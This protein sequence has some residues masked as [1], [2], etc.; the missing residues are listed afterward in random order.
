MSFPT[1]WDVEKYHV[2]HE[3]DEHWE[4]RRRF[5]ETHKDKFPED[6][7]VCLAQVFYNVE[8]MGCRYPEKT[9]RLVAQLSKGVAD[10]HREKMKTKLQRTF[11]QASDAASTKA[12]GGFRNSDATP[13][14]N[15]A[16]E[17][18]KSSDEPTQSKHDEKQGHNQDAHHSSSKNNISSQET[19]SNQG[20]SE[21]TQP[22]RKKPSKKKKKQA[23]K[24]KP[25]EDIFSKPNEDIFSRIVIMENKDSRTEPY[26]TL[27]RSASVSGMTLK[28]DCTK[29]GPKHLVKLFIND[30]LLAAAHGDSMAAAKKQCSEEG[31]AKLRKC[32]YT[33]II[34]DRLVGSVVDKKDVSGA[35]SKVDGAS[36]QHLEDSKASRM[37]KL[38]GWGGGGLGK[39]QQG[40]EEPVQVVEQVRRAGLG[41]HQEGEKVFR[42][43]IT[44]VIQEFKRSNANNELVFASDFSK[45][46]RALIH[47]IARKFN[48]KSVSYGKDSDRQL[49]LSRKKKP[50]EIVKEVLECGGSTDKY[51]IKP[52]EDN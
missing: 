19:S 44:N 37:M 10:D 40:R 49:V 20:I 16:I 14:K 48:L 41:S 7:L 9:M 18:Q 29:E 36:T 33:L 26:G 25:N 31:L 46:E 1:D 43:N 30:T 47:I 34:K 35:K 17:F 42:K 23:K 12:K 32:C 22:K 8:F 39:N 11:V 21:Q 52:P 24:F 38:M 5:L 6:R 50:W 4:L 3:S 27:T 13:K 45:E 28:S 51:E 2:E 15:K